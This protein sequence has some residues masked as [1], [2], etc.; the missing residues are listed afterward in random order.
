MK[1]PHCNHDKFLVKETRLIDGDVVRHRQCGECG[2]HFGTRERIDPDI[3]MRPRKKQVR[4]APKP[5][6]TGNPLFCGVW[7]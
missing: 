7:K 2:G 4:K 3:R 1:C 5:A 6:S